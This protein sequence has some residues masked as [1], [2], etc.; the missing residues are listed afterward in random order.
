M[1]KTIISILSVS[2]I[3]F[4]SSCNKDDNQISDLNSIELISSES[5]LSELNNNSQKWHI[6]NKR[7][8]VVF[9]YDFN[10]PEIT[11]ELLKLLQE[12]FGLASEG[13]LIYP[14]IYPNDFRHGA[15]GYATDLLNELQSEDKDF[16]GVVI[17]GAPDNTHSALAR[18]QD[19]WNREVPYPVIA[20]FPQ[21]EVL[22]IES[23]C[24][25]VLD[26]SQTANMAG[27][28]TQ[29]EVEGQLISEAPE[30][31]VNTIKYIQ[32]LS[33]SLPVDSKLQTHVLQMV[34]SNNIYHYTDPETGLQSI[35]H[36]IL[37]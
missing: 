8:C 33:Y 6:T 28:I 27:E 20:L 37:K 13:G 5:N 11:N 30:V 23:T 22:G 24:D 34:K 26:K 4:I 29:E 21:D 14:L 36:F 16:A 12:N 9:G 19:K 31:L 10:N 1:K 25:L 35:N 3:F 18:N 15:K 7:I 2:L 17:L 32:N